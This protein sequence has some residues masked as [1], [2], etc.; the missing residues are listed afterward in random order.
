MA[1]EKKAVIVGAGLVGAL[2]SG[3]LAKRGY[4]VDV[5]ERRADFRQAGYVGGRSINPVRGGPR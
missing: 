2:W 1:Q 3:F 5:Y 4:T